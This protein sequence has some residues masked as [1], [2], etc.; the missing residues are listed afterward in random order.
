[1]DNRLP[2][3]H[4]NH[5]HHLRLRGALFKDGITMAKINELTPKAR[6]AHIPQTCREIAQQ[7]GAFLATMDWAARRGFDKV[8]PD[9]LR[10]YAQH[11]ELL[12]SLLVARAEELEAAHN[13]KTL[14]G[15]AA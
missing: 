3:F 4:R 7:A 5:H 2:H 14:Q 10:N 11:C 12:Q 6:A 8:T 13:A 9:L 15:V 1:V